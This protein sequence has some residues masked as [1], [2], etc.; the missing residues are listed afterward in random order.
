[1]RIKAIVTDIDGTLVSLSKGVGECYAE[2]LAEFGYNADG[3]RLNEI[4]RSVW[5]EFEPEYLNAANQYRTNSA[6]ERELWHS[7]VRRVLVE[8]GHSCASDPGIVS[9]IY[10]VFSTERFRVVEAGVANFL[11]TAR[12]KGVKLFAATNNDL[13]SKTVLTRLNLASLFDG[14]FVAGELACKKPSPDYFAALCRETGFAAHSMIHIGN[15]PL[16]DFEAPIACGWRA[17]LYDPKGRHST[18]RFGHFDELLGVL[19]L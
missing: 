4:S 15:D 13:R 6:R 16:L 1:M 3:Q 11:V 19:E 8:A 12:G 9:G 7:F 10:E 18:S 17:V 5:K 2:L 14:I